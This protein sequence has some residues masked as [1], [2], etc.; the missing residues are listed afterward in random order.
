MLTDSNMTYSPPSG[1]LWRARWVA[2]AVLFA[3]CLFTGHKTSEPLKQKPPPPGSMVSL[4]LAGDSNVVAPMLRAWSEWRGDW[5][6]R[7]KQSLAWDT[8]FILSYVPILMLG[9]W[10]AGESLAKDGFTSR[11]FGLTIAALQIVA[12]VC[13]FVENWALARV[14]DNYP[15]LDAAQSVASTFSSIKW[16]LIGVAIFFILTGLI[17]S[18][19]R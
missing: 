11:S 12:G 9:C 1:T 16:W 6:E 17:R 14:F 4:E 19:S 10:I 2:L 7:L 3:V 5:R 13:D 8:W 18:L 15:A